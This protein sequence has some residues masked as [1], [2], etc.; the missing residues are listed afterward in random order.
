MAHT[1]HLHLYAAHWVEAHPRWI[2]NFRE[3]T[4]AIGIGALLATAAVIA[5]ETLYVTGPSLDAAAS[6]RFT[7]SPPVVA[8]VNSGVYLP[9]Q[10]VEQAMNA[11]IE[12]LPAQF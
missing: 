6:A 11:R 9:S 4:V 7:A 8:I 3:H 2:A 5:L 10:F 12:D 1:N